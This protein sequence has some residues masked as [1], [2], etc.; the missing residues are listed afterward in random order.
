MIRVTKVL[1]VFVVLCAVANNLPAQSLYSTLTGVVSDPSQALVAQATVRLRDEAVRL[2]ARD[3]HQQRK[4][5]Y[6]F[7]SVPVG[8]YEL[9]VDAPGFETYKETGIALGGGE[10]RNINVTLKLGSTAET[11]VVSDTLEM[12]ATV[13][14]GEKSTT[15]NMKQLENFVQV[16][17]NAAEFIKIMP[18]FG[19]KNGTTNAANFS[20]QTIGINANGNAGSQ[21]PL[22]NAYSYNG[23]PGNTLDITADGAHVS[24]PGCNCDTPV[25]PNA[26]MI[27]EFKV[28]MSNF[29]AENQKGPA[30]ISS[31]AKSGGQDFHGSGFFYARHYALNANDWLFQREQPAAA[32]EQVL[33]SGRHPGRP[34][35]DSRHRLQQE[36]R[37]AVLLYRVRVFLPGAR[38]RPA[39]RH[40]SHRG[41]DSR[42]TSRRRKPRSWATSPPPALP[43]DRSTRGTSRCTR[44]ESSRRRRSTRTCRR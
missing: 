20:G 29:S 8:T 7:A 16:G 23:L 39:A 6:T 17:S 43:R 33:L 1:A 14:S 19:I 37:Q 3:N 38:Y 5:I 35:A 21:S 28:T 36:P 9:T 42:A 31:V 12:L 44:A 24:D 15:L 30:V 26:D 40:G 25:N 22:N 41:H 13:D 27:A 10:R 18:G 2:H 11:V 4:A 32:A 34:G